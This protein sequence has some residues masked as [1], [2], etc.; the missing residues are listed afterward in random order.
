MTLS[1]LFNSIVWNEGAK[2][3]Q[4]TET[5]T[6]AHYYYIIRS[7]KFQLSMEKENGKNKRMQ[8]LESE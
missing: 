1:T 5:L 7:R 2:N 4:T 3:M 8:V 6:M